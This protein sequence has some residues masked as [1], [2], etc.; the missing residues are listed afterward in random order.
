MHY[1]RDRKRITDMGAGARQEKADK[2]KDGSWKA[3]WLG[4]TVL[5]SSSSLEMVRKRCML[6]PFS[7]SNFTKSTLS[8]TRASSMAC[9]RDPTCN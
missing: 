3:S 4:P 8:R 9:S 6:T 1:R 7:M 2:E 5:Y